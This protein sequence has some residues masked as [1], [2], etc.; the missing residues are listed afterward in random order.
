MGEERCAPRFIDSEQRGSRRAGNATDP[1]LAPERG[2]VM[3]ESCG[4]CRNGLGRTMRGEPRPPC[5]AERGAFLRIRSKL[6]QRRGKIVDGELLRQVQGAVGRYFTEC[7]MVVDDDRRA[8]REVVQNG[9]RHFAARVPPQLH[10]RVASE[11]IRVERRIIDIPG[12]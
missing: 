5:R 10:G 11:Q 9:T 1:R 12:D 3:D 4:G 2:G 7:A 6:A 8:A